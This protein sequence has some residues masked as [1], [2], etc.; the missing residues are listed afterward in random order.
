[1][2]WITLQENTKRLDNIYFTY[3]ER[4]IREL[5]VYTIR[6]KL[7]CSTVWNQAYLDI[8]AIFWP[9]HQPQNMRSL[10]QPCE[11]WCRHIWHYYLLG[12]G[13]F[14]HILKVLLNFVASKTQKYGSW[15][16]HLGWIC[17]WAQ[18]TVLLD[19]KLQWEWAVCCMQPK[20]DTQ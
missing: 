1:M 3:Q 15:T 4:Q 7:P 14:L 2:V 20:W 16:Q 12:F 10:S 9:V 13:E 11:C 19:S 17:A 5:P 8:A 18:M 6:H